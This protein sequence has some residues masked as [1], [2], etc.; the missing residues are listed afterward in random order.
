MAWLK[1]L[2]KPRNHDS[3]LDDEYD[4]SPKSARQD[5]RP[6]SAGNLLATDAKDMYRRPD[7]PQEV[8]HQAPAQQPVQ[9]PQ[10]QVPLNKM[11]Q[12]FGNG[13]TGRLM[14][15]LRSATPAGAGP[16]PDLLKQA[17]NEAV[18]PYS[19]KIDRLERELADAQSW[20]GTL[21][22]ERAEIMAWI[23]RRNLRPGKFLTSLLSE[24]EGLR[25][26]LMISS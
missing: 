25:V 26:S 23:D 6:Q 1:R 5:S 20:I 17:F 24:P 18:R 21:E 4:S 9:Q 10:Q 12:P 22:A 14:P 19:E 15:D 3:Y 8:Y 13:S 16:M 7:A 2:S 11:S